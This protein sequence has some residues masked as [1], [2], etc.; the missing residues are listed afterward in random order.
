MPGR[1][2]Y[3]IVLAVFTTT[4]L[5]MGLYVPGLVGLSMDTYAE[6][7]DTVKYVQQQS[8]FADSEDILP[9]T[10]KYDSLS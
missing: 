8:R 5:T 9:A 6:M 3:S 7:S 4:S 2:Q 10:W 1:E